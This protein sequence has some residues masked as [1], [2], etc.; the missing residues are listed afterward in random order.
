[1]DKKKQT[2]LVAAILTGS[3]MLQA[4]PASARDYWHWVAHEHR[5]EHRADIRGDRRDLAEA[6][7]QL[8]WDVQ[9]RAGRRKIAEDRAR[10]ADLERDIHEDR[11]G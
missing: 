7:R 5:W 4:A 8:D 6:R 3:L 11:R 9:H 1:M 10:I 2:L